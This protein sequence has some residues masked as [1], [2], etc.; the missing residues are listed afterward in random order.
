MTNTESMSSQ[1]IRVVMLIHSRYATQAKQQIRKGY[2]LTNLLHF[3]QCIWRITVLNVA[4]KYLLK[5]FYHSLKYKIF[6]RLDSVHNIIE[7]KG[8]LDKQIIPF[9]T[10]YLNISDGFGALPASG[11]L[12]DDGNE[13]EQE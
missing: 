1:I 2:L 8:R 4:T 12:Y 10:H 5:S 13:H 3:Q 6:N 11:P 9:P 7:E